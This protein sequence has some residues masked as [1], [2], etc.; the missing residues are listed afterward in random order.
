LNPLR[1]IP[2]RVQALDRHLA[3]ILFLEDRLP[4]Y[5]PAT[6]SHGL[7]IKA[8]IIEAETIKHVA[9]V[10]YHKTTSVD[11]AAWYAA[12]ASCIDMHA[13]WNKLIARYH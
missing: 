11:A 2:S 5:D 6:A 3:G 7:T 13:F 12:D 4:E 1:L 10:Q 8:M 9:T